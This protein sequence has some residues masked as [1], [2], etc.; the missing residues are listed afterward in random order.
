MTH[1]ELVEC[2]EKRASLSS[3]LAIA[4]G[5]IGALMG[6]AA[7][8]MINNP[9]A[10]SPQEIKSNNLNSLAFIAAGALIGGLGGKRL[11]RGFR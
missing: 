11:A 6:S 9:Y 1:P 3:G 5:S 8:G 7:G 10:V 2:L 4:G